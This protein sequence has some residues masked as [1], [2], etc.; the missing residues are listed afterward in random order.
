MA[1]ATRS[2]KQ[3]DDKS[4]GKQSDVP[5][6]TPTRAKA[7]SKKRKRTSI[8][9]ND[10]RPAVKMPRNGDAAVKEEDHDEDHNA[11][12][13]PTETQ[14]AGDVPMDSVDAQHILDILEMCVWA[15]L[16][17]DAIADALTTGWIL[18]VY[19]TEYFLY[20]L[21]P[22]IP[23]PWTSHNHTSN[24]HIPSGPFSKSLHDILYGFFA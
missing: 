6:P 7:V 2:A 11:E 23:P 15:F 22:P 8:A 4:K 10:E 19:L 9:E 1:R 18:K 12:Q 3:Q 13:K 14:G 17:D 21:T 5:I 24:S 16:P 20:P